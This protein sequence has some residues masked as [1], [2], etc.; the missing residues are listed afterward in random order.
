M[1]KLIASD[2]DGTLLR[3]NKE[4]FSGF[5]DII[6]RLKEKGIYF[7]AASGRQMESLESVF[8][9]VKN[10]VIFIAENGTNIKYFGETIFCSSIDK[11]YASALAN[12]VYSHKNLDI[13]TS[14]LKSAYS[15]DNELCKAMTKYFKYKMSLVKDPVDV[16][17]EIIKIAITDLSTHC[18]K[19]FG[20]LHNFMSDY[21]TITIS[22]D[23]CLDFVKKGVSKGSAIRLIQKRVGA[24]FHSTAA[25]GDNFNDIEMFKEAFYSYA[26]DKADDGV[27]KAARFSGGDNNGDGVAKEIIKLCF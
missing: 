11:K 26:M 15:K 18:R 21:F 7:A 24:D 23:N 14:G 4:L 13:M 19:D 25:F 10:D 22:G 27:K 16:D 1:I 8:E 2:L 12:E 20:N 3:D 9:P 5:F 6:I 17:D